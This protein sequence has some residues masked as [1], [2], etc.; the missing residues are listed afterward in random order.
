LVKLGA[1]VRARTTAGTATL[2]RLRADPAAILTAAGLTPDPWQTELLLRCPSRLLLLAAR[3]VGKS[4]TLGALALYAALTRPGR[5]V[6]LLAP[7]LRQSV[8]LYRKA[9]HAYH[10]LG[11][12]VPAT[13]ENAM[14]LGLANGSR[15][16]A[17]PGEAANVR[18]FTP[19]LVIID[20]A[21]MTNDAL[22][23]ALSPMLAVS[24]GV[25]VAASTPFG[26][27]GWYFDAWEQGG[28]GW[29]RVKVPA[30]LCPRISPA[31]LESERRSLGE[32]WFAQ[33]YECDF[34]STVDSVFDPDAVR[35]A[36]DAGVRPLF[37][38]PS[39]GGVAA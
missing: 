33:E 11:R 4:T 6:L 16:L 21:A 17:L 38:G 2:E 31:F 5:T 32:R 27:R 23:P 7:T 22:L 25:L 19:D 36:L 26:Q 30:A 15:V 34:V 13:K 29:A 24:G 1:A 10:A 37:P 39:S 14:S 18:G 12:P 35:A 20:E 3:Q 8:E 9:A 28:D